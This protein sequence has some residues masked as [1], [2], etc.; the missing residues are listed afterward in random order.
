MQHKL[1]GETY[2]SVIIVI[3]YFMYLNFATNWLFL[4][5]LGRRFRSELRTLLVSKVPCSVTPGK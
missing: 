1:Q 4:F 3:H 2:Y 5:F